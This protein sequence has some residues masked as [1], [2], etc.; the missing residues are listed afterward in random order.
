[1]FGAAGRIR[2]HDPLVRSQVL[3][4]T[5]LQPLYCKFWFNPEL[6]ILFNNLII[7]AAFAKGFVNRVFCNEKD[8]SAYFWLMQTALRFFYMNLKKSEKI[9]LSGFRLV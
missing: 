9:Q 4:P 8:Y 7:K 3:Y 5:E 2:T 6:F 1:M